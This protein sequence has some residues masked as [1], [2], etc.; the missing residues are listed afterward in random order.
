M[1]MSTLG[2]LTAQRFESKGCSRPTVLDRTLRKYTFPTVT[3]PCSPML[4]K[5]T[6]LL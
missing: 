2:S 6:E 3:L 4:E 1:A 5:P